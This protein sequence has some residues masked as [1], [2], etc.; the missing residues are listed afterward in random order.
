M[1]DPF[2]SLAEQDMSTKPLH[3]C[4]WHS[5]SKL[6]AP[7]Y[8]AMPKQKAKKVTL[9]ILLLIKDKRHRQLLKQNHVAL[10]N[11]LVVKENVCHPDL[12]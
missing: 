7:L 10:F 12:N 5:A 1:S 11:A 9:A 3:I 6:Y 8:S 4:L 2:I